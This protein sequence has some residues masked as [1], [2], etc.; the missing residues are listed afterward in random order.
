MDIMKKF[1][2]DWWADDATEEDKYAEWTAFVNDT[3]SGMTYPA[4]CNQ[5]DEWSSHV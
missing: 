2:F 5:I 4:F 3:G 1:Y